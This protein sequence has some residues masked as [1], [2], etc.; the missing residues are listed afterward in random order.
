LGYR[1][2]RASDGHQGLGMSML[3]KPDV[4]LLDMNLPDMSG[5]EVLATLRQKKCQIP[6]IVMTMFGSEN[7]AVETFRLGAVDYL[8]KPFT[9]TEIQ[10][11]IRR[12]LE[13]TC[14]V[15]SKD[16]NLIAA[17]TVR[18]TAAALSHYINNHLMAL[19]GGLSI[20]QENLQ[21]DFPNQPFI[22]KL[23]ADGQSSVNRIEKVMRVLQQITEVR[24]TPYYDGVPM[25]DVEAALRDELP[26]P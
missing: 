16:N 8:S 1:V 7:L 21:S 12:A 15:V 17:E 26:S 6:V 3:H 14:R 23:L 22:S 13:Q 20:L 25:I 4:M 18:Q 24:H 5:L 2:M 19:T 10:Q 11:A 9:P